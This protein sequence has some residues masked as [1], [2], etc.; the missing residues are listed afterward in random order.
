M[1]NWFL[2][3]IFNNSQIRKKYKTIQNIIKI[4]ENY[5]ILEIQE[6]VMQF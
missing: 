5:K 2:N 4:R 6:K 3:K 1:L